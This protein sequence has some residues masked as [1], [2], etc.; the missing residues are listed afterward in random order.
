M[1]LPGNR[2]LVKLENPEIE[3]DFIR[4]GIFKISKE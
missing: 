3:E 4:Y 1:S 2:I